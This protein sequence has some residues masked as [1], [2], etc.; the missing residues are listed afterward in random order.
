M[1]DNPAADLIAHAHDTRVAV[2]G[3]GIAGLVA[4]LE[5]AKVGIAVTVFEAEPAPGGA[6]AQAE[7]DGLTLDVGADGFAPDDEALT[8]LLDELDLGADVVAVPGGTPWITGLPTGAA[9]L[10][11]DTLLGI[12][13]NAWADDVRRIIGWRGAWRAYLDRLRPPMTIGHERR[14]GALVR[15]RLGARVVD[16]L[17]APVV[18]ARFGVAPD[19]LDVELIAP[20]LNTALTR[21]GSL[22]GA[23]AQQLPERR[24]RTTLSGGMGRLVDAL[25]ARIDELGGEVRLASPVTAVERHEARWLVH[26]ASGEPVTVDA[27]IVAIG[28]TAADA[29]LAPVVPAWPSAPGSVSI[30][31]VTLV[32]DAPALDAHP[33]GDAVYPVPGTSPV[34]TLTH[35]TR[36][37]LADAT[38]PGRQVLRVT[39]PVATAAPGAAATASPAAAAADAHPGSIE[40][41]VA[42]V[43]PSDADIVDRARVAAADLLGVELAPG[44]VRAAHRWRAEAAAPASIRDPRRGSVRAAVHRVD[45]L[46]A[47]GAWV[48]GSGLD[49]V[50]ADTRG[51]AERLRHQLLWSRP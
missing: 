2:I 19:D 31:V 25:M 33:R 17:V 9:P 37:P 34:A 40:A 49:T 13:A 43:D 42:G 39:L 30:D 24:D 15:R 29:L 38:G 46:G 18:H 12:P 20:G 8:A 1:P 16:R 22:G 41:T 50:V 47:V 27:V 45:R 26:P 7:L 14:L 44:Q 48:A 28:Q 3:A 4:A 11:A 35:T 51:E 6:I 36:P 21:V 32:V 10:P 23:V 5:F